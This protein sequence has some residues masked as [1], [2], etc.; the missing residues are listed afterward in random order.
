VPQLR[1]ATELP[2]C[3]ALACDFMIMHGFVVLHQLYSSVACKF[4]SCC[5]RASCEQ[6]GWAVCGLGLENR[7]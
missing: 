7:L 5:L 1:V 3:D 2:G 6:Q 4:C